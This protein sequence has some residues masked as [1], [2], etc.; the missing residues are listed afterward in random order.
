MTAANNKKL[1]QTAFAALAD[2]DGAPFFALFADD[3]K[4]VL[5]GSNP[6]S[7]VYAGKET[8][9]TR[10]M[11]PLFAQF[12]TKYRNRASRIVAD[13]DVIVVECKGE[14][15]TKGGKPYDNDYCYVCEMRD[16]KIVTLTEYMDTALVERALEPPEAGKLA[17]AGGRR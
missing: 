3:A 16:G 1:M 4:W 9:R 2:G 5:L 17:D 13:G 10:L 6:W 15:M 8:I 7:G 12:A 14:V 11:K